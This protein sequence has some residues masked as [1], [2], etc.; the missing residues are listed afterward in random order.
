MEQKT[1]SECYVSPSEHTVV[2]VMQLISLNKHSG[3]SKVLPN[4]EQKLSPTVHDII[5]DHNGQFEL[6]NTAVNVY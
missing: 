5:F 1:F 2:R 4:K 6:I 3:L